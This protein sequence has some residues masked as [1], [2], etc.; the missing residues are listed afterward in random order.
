MFIQIARALVTGIYEGKKNVDYVSLQ[1]EGGG[2]L[3]L[4]VPKELMK[5]FIWGAMV[6]IE[7]TCNSRLFNNNLSIQVITVKIKP[8]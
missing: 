7:A 5:E 6:A 8:L 4:S 1:L 3:K 2:E